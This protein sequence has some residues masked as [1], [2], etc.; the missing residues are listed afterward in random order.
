MTILELAKK[1][2]GNL[3]DPLGVAVRGPVG[4]RETCQL[5]EL[6]LDECVSRSISIQKSN[7]QYFIDFVAVVEIAE[8]WLG[9]GL[10][11][12]Q[13]KT[14]VRVVTAQGED[15]VG[16]VLNVANTIW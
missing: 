9:A 7:G 13:T 5:A 4:E 8:P 12:F 14:L 6:N 11:R 10:G 3:M 16:P 1:L 2:D 15:L